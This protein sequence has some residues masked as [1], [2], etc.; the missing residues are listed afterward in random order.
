MDHNLHLAFTIFLAY[1]LK[2]ED[3]D[4]GSLGDDI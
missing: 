3:S 2:K 4:A 1:E